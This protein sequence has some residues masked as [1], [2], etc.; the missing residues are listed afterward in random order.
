MNRILTKKFFTYFILVDQ[1]ANLEPYRSLTFKRLLKMHKLFKLNQYKAHKYINH[2]IKVHVE[3]QLSVEKKL[4][5]P[6]PC[7][8]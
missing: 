5:Q 3:D 6:N 7:A 8:F 1:S 4:G 2:L